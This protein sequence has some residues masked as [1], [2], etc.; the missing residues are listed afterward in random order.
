MLFKAFLLISFKESYLFLR[1]LYGL[2]VHPFKTTAG[3]LQK[4]DWSQTILIFGLPGYLWAF[5]VIFFIS[6]FWFFRNYYEARIILL[7]LFYFSTFLLFLLGI[8]LFYWLAQYF[9][10]CKLKQRN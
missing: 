1:N 7:L 6:V 2:G 8:Y 4:P 5:E 10:Q 9:F 3:I